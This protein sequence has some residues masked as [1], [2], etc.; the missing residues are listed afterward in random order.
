MSGTSPGRPT[1]QVLGWP[2]S[3]TFGEWEGHELDDERLRILYVPPG[4]A[5][6][7]CV[8]SDVADVV[9]KL[10]AYYDP[11]T[12]REIADALGREPEV[13]R[14]SVVRPNL[15]YDVERVEGEDDRVRTLVRRLRELRGASAI[16]CSS[17]Q[18]LNSYPKVCRSES[19]R[20]PG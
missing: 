15:R 16:D 10:D 17:R 5:H 9:Y 18:G 20:M 13:V 7:F 4:F 3:P 6:G 19:E 2:G 14:T 11:A 8:L 12:E 1:T